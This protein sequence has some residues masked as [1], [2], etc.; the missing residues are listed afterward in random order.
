MGKSGHHYYILIY[1]MKKIQN[2][3]YSYLINSLHIFLILSLKISFY[4]FMYVELRDINPPI[5][6][7]D[8][9]FDSLR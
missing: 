4:L 1:Y 8:L 7:G 9:K 6:R 5:F 2:I 3:T